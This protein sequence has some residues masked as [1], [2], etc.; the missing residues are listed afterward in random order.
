MTTFREEAHILTGVRRGRI[1]LV[2]RRRRMLGAAASVEADWRWALEREERH[3]DVVGFYHTHPPGAGVVP[4]ERDVR[5]MRAWCG[6]FGKP[7][8]CVIAC[9]NRIRS[10]LFVTDEDAG[11]R[12]A[13]TE[14]F[15]HGVIV[16]VEG[17]VDGADVSA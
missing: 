10:T 9:G 17:G 15:A 11:R 2:R 1:W 13:L 16:A 12:L 3:G 7:V 14:V 4:S 8:V 6:A 5:T